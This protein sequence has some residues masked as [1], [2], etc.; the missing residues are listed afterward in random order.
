MNKLEFEEFISKIGVFLARQE[1]TTVYN[2]FDKNKDG[3]IQYDEFIGTLRVS[4]PLLT[5]QSDMSER[6]L[7]VVKHAWQV[8]SAKGGN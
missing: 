1:L 3:Q 7:A 5:A 2:F 6:R 4:P 8:L